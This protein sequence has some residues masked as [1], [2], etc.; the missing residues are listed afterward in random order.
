[1][2]NYIYYGDNL[3]IIKNLLENKGSFIDLIYIDTSFN[4][5]RNYNI[6]YKDILKEDDVTQIEAFKD[7]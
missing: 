2:E 3:E 6:L 7:T 5:K 1:M 4:S